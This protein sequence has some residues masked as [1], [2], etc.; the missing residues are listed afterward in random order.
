MTDKN[1]KDQSLI[2]DVNAK[3]KRLQFFSISAEYPD[4]ISQ[5]EVL[6]RIKTSFSA[7]IFRWSR[8][9]ELARSLVKPVTDH[10]FWN[11]IQEFQI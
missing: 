8:V 7:G 2:D 9:F 6:I 11:M 1:L 3:F 4:I 10:D 5:H